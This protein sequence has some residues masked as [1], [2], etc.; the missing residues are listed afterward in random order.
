M[1]VLTKERP[2][3]RQCPCDRANVLSIVVSS[4][5]VDIE[6]ELKLAADFLLK[7][8]EARDRF[9]TTNATR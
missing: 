7:Q 2:D 6:K 1:A 5:D 3:D 8:Q 9:A 4:R